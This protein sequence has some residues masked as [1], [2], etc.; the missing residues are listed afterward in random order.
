[1]RINTELTR[2]TAETVERFNAAFNQHDV[3]GV[4]ALMTEDCV[5]EDTE[6]APDG[7]RFEGQAA[8][9]ACW[10]GLFAGAPEALF[11][12]E[13]VIVFEDRAIV[14]WL[15]RWADDTPSQ[16]GHVRGVDVIRVRDGKVAEKLS[17]VKG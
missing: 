14:R 1:V 4:M 5:F 3:E 11:T 7:G 9:R 15:Y 13:E 6:P 10:E 12:A 2:S 16:P 17:Y 8:V